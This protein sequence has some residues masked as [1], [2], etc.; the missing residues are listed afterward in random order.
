MF[1]VAADETKRQRKNRDETHEMIRSIYANERNGAKFGF[2][3][4]STYNAVV[5]YLDFY[6]SVDGV[7]SAV[8]SM[9][10]TSSI[11]QKKLLAHRWVVS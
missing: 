10:D 5:E 7:S 9:D 3:A 6:R 8:A 2:N 4:W 11:T 1:P